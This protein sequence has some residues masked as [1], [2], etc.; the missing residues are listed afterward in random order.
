MKVRFNENQ[1]IVDAVEGRRLP[2]LT[3]EKLDE[4]VV[5]IIRAALTFMNSKP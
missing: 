2:V 5:R 1:E 3:E 4:S